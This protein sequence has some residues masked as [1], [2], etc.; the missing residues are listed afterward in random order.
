[1][2]MWESLIEAIEANAR[3]VG[4]GVGTAWL[5]RRPIPTSNVDIYNYNIRGNCYEEVGGCLPLKLINWLSR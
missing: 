5:A 3:V 1:M 4:R 2:R